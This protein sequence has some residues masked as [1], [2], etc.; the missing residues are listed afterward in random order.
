MSSGTAS[1]VVQIDLV[2]LSLTPRH[3][4]LRVGDALS[5]CNAAPGARSTS[6]STVCLQVSRMGNAAESQLAQHQLDTGED[7]F[8]ALAAE[9]RSWASPDEGEVVWELDLLPPS[10]SSAQWTAEQPGFYWFCSEVYPFIKGA[11]RVIIPEVG[12]GACAVSTGVAR[13]WHVR[14]P[15]SDDGLQLIVVQHESWGNSALRHSCCITHEVNI[16]DTWSLCITAGGRHPSN[17]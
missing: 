11:V 9:T 17:K 15:L 1:T 16:A 12:R 13:W 4:Q 10:G 7:S 6:A 8:A 5:F 3:L 2:N 14:T